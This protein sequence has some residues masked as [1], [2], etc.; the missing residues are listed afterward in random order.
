MIMK[1]KLRTL[2]VGEESY[3]YSL[4]VINLFDLEESIFVIRIFKDGFSKYPLLISFRTL[5]DYYVGNPL[6]HGV[7]LYNNKLLKEEVINLN[8]PKFI[9]QA[10]DYGI[11]TGWN[12][13]KDKMECDGLLLLVELGYDINKL[14]KNNI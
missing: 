5:D 13:I 3:L 12:G 4:Q 2:K 1:K 11:R 8:R 10:L 6:H 7:L 14:R 9:R